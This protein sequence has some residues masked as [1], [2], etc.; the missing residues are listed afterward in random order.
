M[1][2]KIFGTMGF[3]GSRE[4]AKALVTLMKE[5]WKLRRGTQA[6]PELP[7]LI[8]WVRRKADKGVWLTRGTLSPPKAKD[9]PVD[10]NTFPAVDLSQLEDV[11]GEITGINA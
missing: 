8:S 3:S 2:E 11:D 7:K 9:H 5:E 10:V 6:M 1:I 4:Q